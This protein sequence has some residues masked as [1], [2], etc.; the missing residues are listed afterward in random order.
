MELLLSRGA[1]AASDNG[2]REQK[3]LRLFALLMLVITI[4]VGV[5]FLVISAFVDTQVQS[6]FQAIVTSGSDRP[7]T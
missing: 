7:P 6:F 2:P 3:A 1:L 5:E 4:I